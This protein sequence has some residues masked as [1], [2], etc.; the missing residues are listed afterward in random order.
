MT[1]TEPPAAARD[2]REEASVEPVLTI[3]VTGNGEWCRV[4]AAGELDVATVDRLDEAL[5]DAL[6]RSPMLVLDLAGI[7]FIDSTGL[8]ALV[9][10]RQRAMRSRAR[11]VL[12]PSPIVRRLLVLTS[13]TDTF[14]IQEA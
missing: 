6:G 8:N 4:T 2:S 7:A 1:H 12:V 14:E 3:G 5:A 11:F 13:L 9:R 10:A